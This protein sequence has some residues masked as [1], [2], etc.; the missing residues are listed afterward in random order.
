M[1]LLNLLCNCILL[2]QELCNAGLPCIAHGEPAD[3]YNK[4]V[5]GL[6]E[7]LA[8]DM[9]LDIDAPPPKPVRRR[10]QQRQAA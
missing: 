10:G 1:L 8:S 7:L 4:V 2:V 9:L 5:N 6:R 3:Y